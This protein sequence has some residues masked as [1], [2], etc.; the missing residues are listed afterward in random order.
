MKPSINDIPVF[1]PDTLSHAPVGDL[2][3]LLIEHGDRVP[4][5]L[6]DAC[7][8]RD[9]DMVAALV[10]FYA[11]L[12]ATDPDDGRDTWWMGLH[13]LLLLGAIPGEA[14]G[15]LLIDALRRAG[16]EDDLVLLDW[17]A[18]DTAWLF[19]NKPPAV[20]DQARELV[21]DRSAGWYLRCIMV[22]AV[23]AAGLATGPAELDATLDW[24]ADLLKD[25]SDDLDFRLLA[26]STLLDFPRA[27]HRALL[28]ATA[29]EQEA[30]PRHGIVFGS[31]DVERRFGQAKDTPTW[32][33]RNAPWV[34]YDEAAILARQERWR[35]EDA[36]ALNV[37]ERRD[38]LY[39]FSEPYVREQPKSGRNAPCHCGSGMKYKKCCL[40][41][42][43]THEA[44]ARQ[45]H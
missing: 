12:D 36:R 29:A 2:L 20:I 15:R 6:F 30:G 18:G 19:A 13:A 34:F 14:A 31:D 43:E 16:R 4:R 8:A 44:L 37:M 25:T 17:V 38:G 1:D 26:A 7:V 28:N 42:D 41:A 22:D 39:D 33:R 5:A 9:E 11:R 27:R 21:Q 10:D 23:L 24:L 40:S 32:V 35:E 3:D 45:L